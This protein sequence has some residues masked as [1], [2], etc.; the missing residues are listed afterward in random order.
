MEVTNNLVQFLV[1]CATR[2]TDVVS[3]SLHI[4]T[5]L[6]FFERLLGI[7]R[8]LR[9]SLGMRMGDLD[10]V[11]INLTEHA[12]CPRAHLLLEF[13]HYLVQL[14]VICIPGYEVF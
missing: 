1:I 5:D 11:S 10:L 8:I 14:L 2:Y 6:R 4:R 3:G 7:L 12:A 9:H 13:A